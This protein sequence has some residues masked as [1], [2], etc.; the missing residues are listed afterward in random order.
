MLLERLTLSHTQEM[1][2]KLEEVML[3]MLGM[4]QNLE[5]IHHTK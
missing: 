1:L 3:A 2:L 4:L 5:F